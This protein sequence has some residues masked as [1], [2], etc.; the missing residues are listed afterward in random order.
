M[1]KTL[2]LL[3]CLLLFLQVSCLTFAEEPTE[4]APIVIRTAKEL[5]RFA[6]N[7][8]SDTYSIG[9]N[10]VLEADIDALYRDTGY[11]PGTDFE[12]GI[13]KTIEYVKNEMCNI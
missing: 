5:L 12:S 7:C 8:A 10:F 13:Q 2:S 4:E 1:K 3:L 11:I 9:R 6:Q